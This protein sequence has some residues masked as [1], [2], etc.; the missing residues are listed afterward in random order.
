MIPRFWLSMI[1]PQPAFLLPLHSR[2]LDMMWM[3]RLKDK[4]VSPKSRYSNHPVSFWMSNIT[5]MSGYAV[6][7]QVQQSILEHQVYIILISAKNAPLDLSYGMR[8]GAHGCLPKPFSAEVLIQAVWEGVPRTFT[9]NCSP[10]FFLNFTTKR[11]ASVP[12]AYSSSGC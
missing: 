12:G 10:L 4:R 8:Q 1:V 11:A 7:R 2:K 3:L 5:D 6:C 9:S